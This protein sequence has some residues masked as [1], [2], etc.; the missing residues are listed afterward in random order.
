MISHVLHKSFDYA[1]THTNIAEREKKKK[2]NLV[3]R[4]VWQEGSKKCVYV[5]VAVNIHVINEINCFVCFSFR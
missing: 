5:S 4:V 2:L 3:R 1:H